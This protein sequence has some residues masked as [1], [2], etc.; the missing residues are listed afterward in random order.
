MIVAERRYG[1]N[2]RKSKAANQDIFFDY[3]LLF[4]VLFLLAFGL[5]MLYSA[6]SYDASLHY[7]GDS[8]YFLKRQAVSTVMGLVAMIFVANI[9]YHFWERFA[10]VGCLISIGLIILVLTPLGYEANG[11]RRW[12]RLFGFSIQENVRLNSGRE[13]SIWSALELS[14][15]DTI[16]RNAP[17]KTET[18]I[19]RQFDEDG[20]ELSEGQKQKLAL[21]RTFYRNCSFVILDEPSSSLDPEA[22]DKVLHSLEQFSQGKIALFTSHRLT[23]VSIAERIIVL[24]NGRILEE[25]TQEELLQHSGRFAELYAYQAEKFR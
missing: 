2:Q 14:G 12:L 1:K 21:A 16:A 13:D 3:T 8:A 9:P 19:T 6:S 22:E 5:V 20:I 7:E 15:A 23:N 10:A 18:S 17:R 25:G 11:A 24:E 4:I